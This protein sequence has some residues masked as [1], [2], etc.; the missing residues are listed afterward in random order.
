MHKNE[1][2]MGSLGLKLGL[3]WGCTK[4]EGLPY[5]DTRGWTPIQVSDAQCCNVAAIVIG[6]HLFVLF[7]PIVWHNNGDKSDK[8]TF[9]EASEYLDIQV[10]LG[11]KDYSAF[12]RPVPEI[13]SQWILSAKSILLWLM[14]MTCTASASLLQDLSWLCPTSS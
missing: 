12:H 5:W 10:R 9:C 13:W 7:A 4:K 6:W 8:S 14:L 1:L 2:M 3:Q 11:P